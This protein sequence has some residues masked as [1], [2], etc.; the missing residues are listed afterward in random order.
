MGKIRADIETDSKKEEKEK[1]KAYI[2]V[3]N[4]YKVFSSEQEVKGPVMKKMSAEEYREFMGAQGVHF[5]KVTTN[6]I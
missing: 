5:G 2:K 3:N 1:M 4:T 6:A